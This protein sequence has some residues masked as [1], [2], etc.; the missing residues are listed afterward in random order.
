MTTM[1]EKWRLALNDIRK[2]LEWSDRSD[3]AAQLD[4]II[5]QMDTMD[6]RQEDYQPVTH[7]CR[8]GVTV[9]YGSREDCAVC[10]V[11]KY[12]NGGTR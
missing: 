11:P 4:D 12:W 1:L 5:F 3:I 7:V 9:V 2:D 10:R 6:P 8:D